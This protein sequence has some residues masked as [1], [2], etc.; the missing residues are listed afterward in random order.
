MVFT[1][2]IPALAADWATPSKRL[3]CWSVVPEGPDEAL[4]GDVLATGNRDDGQ[5]PNGPDGTGHVGVVTYPNTQLTGNSNAKLASAA[6]VAPP[7][8]PTGTEFQSG[9]IT[10]TDYGFRVFDPSQSAQ[11]QG[12]KTDSTVRRFT[13]Y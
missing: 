8:W 10:L 2:Q 1:T 3:S 12:L 6:T 7:Y 4:P 11:N 5:Y 13:C 9:T